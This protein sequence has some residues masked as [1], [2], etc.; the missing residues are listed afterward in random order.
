MYAKALPASAAVIAHTYC[1]RLPLL[2]PRRHTLLLRNRIGGQCP[3]HPVIGARSRENIKAAGPITVVGSRSRA[4]ECTD[5]ALRYLCKQ[6]VLLGSSASSMNQ[7]NSLSLDPPATPESSTNFCRFQCRGSL[8]LASDAFF[9]E[10]SRDRD[11]RFRV[12]ISV[13][14][15][16]AGPAIKFVSRWIAR[17]WKNKFSA[18]FTTQRAR[19]RAPKWCDNK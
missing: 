16:R 13:G 8:I 3:H 7:F 4:R 1:A 17:K 9:A 2:L 14:S 6:R 12:E 15:D 18:S 10:N 11:L 19:A 5:N